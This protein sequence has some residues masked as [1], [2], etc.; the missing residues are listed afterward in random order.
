[1]FTVAV[2]QKDLAE[3]LLYG[4][5]E[6][7]LPPKLQ[8]YSHVYP[9]SIR[10]PSPLSLLCSPP[11]RVSKSPA[12]APPSSF[13]A[14]SLSSSSPLHRALF[15]LHHAATAL[16]LISGRIPFS[17]AAPLSSHTNPH[18]RRYFL[19]LPPPPREF[20]FPPPCLLAAFSP[21][22]ALGVGTVV[23]GFP[24]G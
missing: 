11:H 6:T 10:T 2:V 1:M 22:C 4:G 15:F 14:A 23:N 18:R 9:S 24:G 12:A 16:D 5:A 20:S 8:L 3:T 19:S 21:V 7:I 13:Q 17:F